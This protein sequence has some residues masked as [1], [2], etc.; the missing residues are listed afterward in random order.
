MIMGY[1]QWGLVRLFLRT[2]ENTENAEVR[3]RG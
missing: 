1:T 2:A 3:G